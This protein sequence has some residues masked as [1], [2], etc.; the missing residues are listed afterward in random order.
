MQAS[1]PRVEYLGFDSHDQHREFRFRLHVTEGAVELRVRIPLAAFADGRVRMQDGPAVCYQRLVR[2][3]ATGELVG[4]D[5]I[6]IDDAELAG[7]REAHTPPARNRSFTPSATAKPAARNPPRAPFS[8]PPVATPPP[9]PAPLFGVGQRVRH[10]IFGDGV[11]ASSSGGLT[12]VCFDEGS[13]KTFVTSILELDILSAP[14]T[15]ETTRRGVNQAVA[16]PEAEESDALPAE[17]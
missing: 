6:T 4:Q 11:T 9:E 2:A 14:H 12:V 15:W 7:Y 10:A 17:K 8:R 3:A 13:K 1:P 5:V 16:R